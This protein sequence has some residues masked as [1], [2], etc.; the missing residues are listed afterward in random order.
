MAKQRHAEQHEAQADEHMENR[1]A[2][3]R[4][5]QY[6]QG[7]DH[8]LHKIEIADDDYRRDRQHL[9]EELKQRQAE[10]DAESVIHLGLVGQHA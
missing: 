10:K 6:F 1:T 2:D 4:R 9:G 5:R 3:I 8:F 7:K